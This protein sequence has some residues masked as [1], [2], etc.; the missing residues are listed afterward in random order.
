MDWSATQSGSLLAFMT[1]F[2]VLAALVMPALAQRRIDRRPFLAISLGAQALG[3]FGLL[4]WPLEASHVWV[5]LIGFG[6]GACFALSLILTLDHCREPRA[7]GQLAAFVQGVGFLI[8]AVSPWLT[9][10]LR[11]LTG[12]FVSAWWV[13]IVGVVSMLILTRV[14]SPASYRGT[15]TEL[16]PAALSANA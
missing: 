5:A 6:L 7:A 9:G 1:V 15:D 2:Q 16:Q 14:F 11:E 10:W 13:L 8:N 4:M 3:F 12:S